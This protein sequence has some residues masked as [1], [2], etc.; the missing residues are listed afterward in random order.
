MFVDLLRL[1]DALWA[2]LPPED[3]RFRIQIAD[4]LD[5]RPEPWWKNLRPEA[6]PDFSC[7]NSSD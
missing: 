5:R 1:L 6:Q 7:K 3:R 4:E 2:N